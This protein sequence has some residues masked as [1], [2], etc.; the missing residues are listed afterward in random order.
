MAGAAPGASA[1]DGRGAGQPP[2]AM[3]GGVEEPLTA[4]EEI[5][6]SGKTVFILGLAFAAATELFA[7]IYFVC[8]SHVGHSCNRELKDA[9]IRLVVC[10]ACIGLVVAA[11][12]LVTKQMFAA[13]HHAALAQG[14]EREGNVEG[15]NA[16]KEQLKRAPML[17]GFVRTALCVQSVFSFACLGSL[18]LGVYEAY[19]SKLE[20]CGAGPVV[21]LWPLGAA[22]FFVVVLNHFVY[23]CIDV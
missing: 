8:A 4:E 12:V 19:G 14:Y 20:L 6:R 1:R 22:N 11:G 23:K 10:N 7:I 5:Q 9:Y 3:A 2:P 21:A 18:G 13:V 16:E 17:R 15:A